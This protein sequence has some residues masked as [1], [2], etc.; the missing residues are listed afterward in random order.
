[1]VVPP[2]ADMTA[3]AD[4]DRALRGELAALLENGAA[5]QTLPRA[6]SHSQVME[7]VSRLQD[8]RA[9]DYA[10][11]LIVAGFTLDPY[12]AA[13]DEDGGESGDGDEQACETCMYYQAHR[14]FCE[15]PELMLPVE[16]RW[17][18]ILWRI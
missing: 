17:S 5:T 6:Y 3:A 1:M 14:R 8:L 18:C 9:D 16:P 7:V 4:R 15:L 2:M 10:N 12:V 13:S 11:K